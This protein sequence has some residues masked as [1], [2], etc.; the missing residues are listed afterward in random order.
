MLRD[1]TERYIIEKMAEISKEYYEP[2]DL[3]D[4]TNEK[5]NEKLNIQYEIYKQMLKDLYNF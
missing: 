2:Y 1:K 3:E 5:K 4:R